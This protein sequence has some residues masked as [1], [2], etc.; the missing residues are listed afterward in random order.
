[1]KYIVRVTQVN[2]VYNGI[3]NL[4]WSET[5]HLEGCE[6]LIMSSRLSEQSI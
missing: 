4:Q 3:L 2:K 1:M 6:S 5:E